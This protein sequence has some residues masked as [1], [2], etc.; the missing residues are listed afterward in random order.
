MLAGK[1][2]INSD[3]NP[4]AAARSFSILEAPNPNIQIA[5]SARPGDIGKTGLS[6][7]DADRVVGNAGCGTGCDQRS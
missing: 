5:L 7:Y 6:Q 3:I 4:H 2:A 1:T